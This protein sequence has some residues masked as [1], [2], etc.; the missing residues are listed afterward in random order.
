MTDPADLGPAIDTPEARERRHA[1]KLLLADMMEMRHAACLL[2]GHVQVTL[3]D[4]PPDLLAAAERYGRRQSA[5]SDSERWEYVAVFGGMVVFKGVAGP[6]A[7]ERSPRGT[8]VEDEH[9][10]STVEMRPIA[11]GGGE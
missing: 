6:P 3:S 8:G 5:G 9:T 1:V 7:R 4:C 11:A 2:G 10:R